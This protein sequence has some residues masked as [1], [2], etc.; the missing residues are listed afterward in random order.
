MAG[1]LLAV[2]DILHCFWVSDSAP[3]QCIGPGKEVD[4]GHLDGERRELHRRSLELFNRPRLEEKSP[5]YH[6]GLSLILFT[7]LTDKSLKLIECTINF[8]SFEWCSFVKI[9]WG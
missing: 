4:H 9:S 6:R 2:E 7:M 3:S 8:C 5:H 1:I